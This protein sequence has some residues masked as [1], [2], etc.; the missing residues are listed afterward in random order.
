MRPSRLAEVVV[1]GIWC[2]VG[3]VARAQP[4][5]TVIARSGNGAPGTSASY[6]QLTAP[7]INSAGQVA[8]LATLTGPGTGTGNDSAVFAGMPGAINLLVRAGD[9]APGTAPGVTFA[10]V[11]DVELAQLNAQGHVMLF[12]NHA[13]PGVTQGNPLYGYWLA[14]GGGS[15]LPVALSRDLG[16]GE[17]PAFPLRRP[18]FTSGD[19]GAWTDVEGIR[20]WSA[21]SGPSAMAHSG[22]ELPVIN[23]S[24]EL[25]FL[26]SGDEGMRVVAGGSG[27][28]APVAAAGMAAPGTPA[29]TRFTMPLF[30]SI[31]AA[32][33]VAFLAYIDTDPPIPF[34]DYA[35]TTS[36]WRATPKAGGAGF[37]LTL[38]ARGGDIAP[39]TGGQRFG[40]FD[41]D[42]DSY[43]PPALS[44]S[45]EVAFTAWLADGGG[46]GG[47]GQSSGLFAGAPG[48]VRLVAR[49]GQHAN[50]APTGLNLAALS[51]MD[52]Y[53]I[54]A[55]G[56]V[57]FVDRNELGIDLALYAADVDGSLVYLA[58]T[59]RPFVLG[60][61]DVRTVEFIYFGEGGTQTGGED[62]RPTALNDLGQ[63]AFTLKFT[64]GTYATM[65]TTV[66]EPGA[67]GALL[68]SGM[69]LSARRAWRRRGCG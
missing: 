27:G 1:V 32:G 52:Q 2:A 28:P 19:Q 60:P 25:A 36:L 42:I 45:G 16:S 59:G 10:D 34:S 22:I 56:Q 39:G 66:P 7:S 55:R 8:F 38:V 49:Q 24:G 40:P 29:G 47:G 44:P 65:I 17:Y 35:S 50:N 57:A 43:R 58:A 37:E 46:G 31:N 15:V 48:A 69:I 67:I 3:G 14:A 5:F 54:N 51:S 6:D 64:D 63:L 23:P 30:P 4:S 53:V 11:F 18:V 62:G 20:Y 68:L 21:S 33:Q 61:G 26:T 13:G 12:A 41:L 9:A